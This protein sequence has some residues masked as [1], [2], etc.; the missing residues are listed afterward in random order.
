MWDSFVELLRATIF[1]VAHVCGGSLG[2]GIFLVSAGIRLALLPLTL[3]IA[4]RARD[5]QVRIAALRP[6]LEALQRRYSTDLRSLTRETRALYAAH[7]IK[8]LTPSGVVGIAIQFPL[9]SGLFAAVR[10]GLGSKV[11]F[12]WV[13]DLARPDG[14]LLLGVAAMT[15]WGLSSVQATPGRSGAPTTLIVAVTLGTVAFLWSASSAVALSMGASSLVSV[16]QNWLLSRDARVDD[17][18]ADA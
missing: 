5:Q 18:V 3:R 1:T 14:L 13:P 4:R 11:R 10:R 9:L 15:A 17:R 2:G 7:D 6:Q 12:L 16:L 8:L